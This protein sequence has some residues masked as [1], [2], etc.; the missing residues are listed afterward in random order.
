M[1]LQSRYAELQQQGIGLASITYEPPDVL[2]LFADAK[3]ITFPMLSDTGS[4]IIRRYDLLNREMR[5][6]TPEEPEPRDADGFLE[7][8]GIPY[9]GTF[10][11]DPDGRVTE[12]FFES[13]YQ[14]RFTV[15]SIAVRLG[16][17]LAGTDRDATR[18]AT[19]HLELLAYPSDTIVAPGNRVALVLDVTPQPSMHVYAPGDHSYKVIGLTVNA[20]TFIQ[21]HDVEYPE[22]EIYH[23]EPLDERVPVYQKPFRLIQDVTIPMSQDT[24]TMAAAPDGTLTIEGTVEYQACDATICYNPAEIPV[25]WTLRW[26]PL[27]F[28]V[29][30]APDGVR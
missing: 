14:E 18:I 5:Q 23:Y 10:M 2:R 13:R 19:N 11:L 29:P 20:P 9:P 3:G 6:S 25:S 15:S 22:S 17:V 1:E 28:E 4:A 12:R 16:D 8:Y 21:A 7:H 24:A 26:R 30:T 27:E